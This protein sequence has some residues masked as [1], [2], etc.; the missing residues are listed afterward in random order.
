MWLVRVRKLVIASV[1][2]WSMEYPC[3]DSRN[4]SKGFLS[5]DELPLVSVQ[6][7]LLFGSVRQKLSDVV[8]ILGCVT[9]VDDTS[10]TTHR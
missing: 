7:D 2:N 1:M 4:R 6:C 5:L 10:S 9:V 8:G 3:V